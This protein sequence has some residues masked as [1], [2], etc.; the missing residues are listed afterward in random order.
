MNI[1]KTLFLALILGAIILYIYKVQIPKDTATGLSS[2]LLG[3]STSADLTKLEVR[4]K[5]KSFTLVRDLP[6]A[7][8]PSAILP[9]AI[10]PSAIPPSTSVSSSSSSSLPSA[11]EGWRMTERA[12]DQTDS[13]KVTAL[14]NALSAANLGK[15]LPAEDMSEDL[16]VYG[17]KDPDIVIVATGNDAPITVELGKLNAFVNQRYVK[18]SGRDGIFL[19]P[20]TIFNAAKG[21]A[22][23]FRQHSPISFADG[24]LKKI[25]LTNRF[26]TQVFEVN[27]G[28]EWLMIEP[29]AT[30][31]SEVAITGMLRA[32]R[33]IKASDF[34]ELPTPDLKLYGLAKPALILQLDYRDAD[35]APLTIKIGRPGPEV[36]KDNPLSDFFFQVGD[37]LTI[38]RSDGADPI[39]AIAKPVINYREKQFFKLPD[40]LVSKISFNISGAPNAELLMT[41]GKWQINGK[42]ADEPFVKELIKN[43][44]EVRASGFPD[45]KV[46][47]DKFGFDKPRYQ[48][49]VTIGDGKEK[50]VRTMTL[51]VGDGVPSAPGK[52]VK[53]G[54]KTQVFY[55][56]VIEQRDSESQTRPEP[57]MSEVFLLDQASVTRITPKVETLR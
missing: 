11:A 22:T 54:D 4:H 20:D 43:L 48:A 34:I 21:R 56:Q 3:G 41:D 9:S 35:K 33:T 38:F 26:G 32:L 7:I 30:K 31:A 37:N 53:K 36:T 1:R 13:S 6:S 29:V 10:L 39:S 17:L 47:S 2:K 44:S 8:L 15:S 14:I 18:V 51:N 28:F 27:N 12:W 24:E 16:S 46:T 25:A 19:I 23:D 57:K 49:I 50:T 5:E 42:S 40:D 55:A 45:G 52:A